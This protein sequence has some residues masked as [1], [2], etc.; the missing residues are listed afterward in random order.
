MLE[1]L[2]D[3]LPLEVTLA[4]K[5]EGDRLKTVTLLMR[6]QQLKLHKLLRDNKRLREY[7]GALDEPP[8]KKLGAAP[9]A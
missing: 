4:V 1:P 2:K 3:D 6:K 8:K 5:H 9:V 7:L